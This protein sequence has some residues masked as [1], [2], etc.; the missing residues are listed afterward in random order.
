MTFTVKRHLLVDVPSEKAKVCVG[1]RE[2]AV[3]EDGGAVIG[4]CG[5]PL[6]RETPQVNALPVNRYT[7]NPRAGFTGGARHTFV[8]RHALL[9]VGPFLVSSVTVVAAYAQIASAIVKRV[10]VFVVNKL[11]RRFFC[12]YLPVEFA[13]P[14][15]DGPR[16]ASSRLGGYPRVGR[17]DVGV[18]W[19]D[20]GHEAAR[21]HRKGAIPT[22]A[23][24]RVSVIAKTGFGG[25]IP[26][27]A[28]ARSHLASPKAVSIHPS[29][30]STIAEAR[31]AS[32]ARVLLNHK[33]RKSLTS[34][35]NNFC[36]P[37]RISNLSDSL[38]AKGGV[39]Q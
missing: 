33:P 24:T 36:H 14:G 32:T 30:L 27:P 29:G 11:S 21:Q 9:L 19:A 34:H 26:I 3:K 2:L 18:I 16:S 37:F 12:Q 17:K 4:D 13:A 25:P 35:V 39:V 6:V 23:K 5:F 15:V 1:L 20:H 7:G 10:A 31:P 22:L 38:I 8:L 28:S